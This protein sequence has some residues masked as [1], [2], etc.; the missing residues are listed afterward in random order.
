MSQLSKAESFYPPLETLP[1]SDLICQADR[2]FADSL[3][4]ALTVP[5]EGADQ[6]RTLIYLAREKA[7]SNLNF[8]EPVIRARILAEQPGQIY[9]T[10]IYERLALLFS[11]VGWFEEYDK[12]LAKVNRDHNM[13]DSFYFRVAQDKAR[14]GLG[15]FGE[16]NYVKSRNH[17]I[18]QKLGGR[19]LIEADASLAAATYLATGVY[20]EEELSLLEREMEQYELTYPQD[21]YVLH[22]KEALSRAFATCRN[23]ER[24]V[25]WADNMQ[26]KGDQFLGYVAVPV[27]AYRRLAQEQLLQRDYNGVI[28][29]GHKAISLFAFSTLSEQ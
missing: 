3:R 2:D 18:G 22:Y 13:D 21:N 29:S 8:N 25:F 1:P 15:P 26:V 19:V 16:L 5:P 23:L 7:R 10:M 14:Y 11:S 27:V 4:F 17:D 24:A 28:A 6:A 9:Q 20:S 12:E